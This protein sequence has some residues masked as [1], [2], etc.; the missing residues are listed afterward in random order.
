MFFLYDST[1]NRVTSYINCIT[2]KHAKVKEYVENT[3]NKVQVTISGSWM[4]LDFD[5]DGSVSIEDMKKSMFSLYDFLKNYDVIE[6]TTDIKSKLY[7]DAIKYMQT[8]LE[9]DKKAMEIR[10]QKK[11]E[12]EAP[13]PA[14]IEESSEKKDQ[15]NWLTVWLFYKI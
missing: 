11:D 9:Q 14:Q 13:K 7:T 3:Y 15:W 6:K 5:H 4:R 12:S 1:Q 2:D 8:E 10:K